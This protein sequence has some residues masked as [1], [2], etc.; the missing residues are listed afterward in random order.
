M[1]IVF[2]T[3]SSSVLPSPATKSNPAP[4]QVADRNGGKQTSAA[5]PERR[6]RELEVAGAGRQDR[7][8]A[9]GPVR[10]GTKLP[11]GFVP[12]GRDKKDGAG[13]R[14]EPSQLHALADACA[15]VVSLLVNAPVLLRYGAVR[16]GG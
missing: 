3:H 7:V 14:C 15:P 4:L 10:P 5:S 8:S 13:G 1:F 12:A 2:L 9:R 11:A 16:A 6:R